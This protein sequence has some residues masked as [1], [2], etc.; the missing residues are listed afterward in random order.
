MDSAIWELDSREMDV[1][2]DKY[3]LVHDGTLRQRGMKAFVALVGP[4]PDRRE[5]AELIVRLHNEEEVKHG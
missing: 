1:L 2:G 3:A 5:T 4:G